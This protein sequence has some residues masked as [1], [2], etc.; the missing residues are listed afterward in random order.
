MIPQAVRAATKPVIVSAFGAML[1]GRNSA[2]RFHI[3]T[4]HARSSSDLVGEEY[5]Y[6]ARASRS[7]EAASGSSPMFAWGQ[8]CL[9]PLFGGV[10]SLM[11]KT[12][13]PSGRWWCWGLVVCALVAS[14]SGDTWQQKAASASTTQKKTF[15]ECFDRK[16]LYSLIEYIRTYGVRVRYIHT[17]IPV[18]VSFET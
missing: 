4:R 18:R 6:D 16:F 5:L 8:C 17:Y 2:K 11:M 9:P 7:L 15:F 10:A 3:R 12:M 13:P 14:I 1:R